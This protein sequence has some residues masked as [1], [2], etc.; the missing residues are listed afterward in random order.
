MASLAGDIQR[1]LDLAADFTPRPSPP[2]RERAS[3]LADLAGGLDRALDGPT[4]QP[5][6]AALGLQV[7]AGGQQ[8]S[9]ALVPWVRIY[10][11]E[12]SPTAQEGIYLTYLFAADGS[13]AY[14]SLMHGSSEFRSGSMR[15]ITDQRVLLARAA[16]ARSALGD[17]AEAGIA[18]GA[19]LSID[20]AWKG[21]RSPDRAKAYESANILART[22]RAG[23][24]PSDAQL[25]ADLSGMLPL[26]ARLYGTEPELLPA[27]GDDDGHPAR[28]A[29]RAQGRE[30][31]PDI[32]RAIE[33]YAENHAAAYF[34]KQKWQVKRVGQYKLGY[35]LACTKPNGATLHVEVKGTRTL[36]EKVT[37]TANEVEHTS[38]AI[39]CGAEHILYVLSQITVTES[40]AITCSGGT[41][42][43]LWPW[44]I[45]ANDLIATEYAYTVPIASDKP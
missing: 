5:W 43:R 18:A 8:G 42:T 3:V 27:D 2:M 17:M 21:F 28:P 39:D 14:L 19:S 40:G 20:L 25:L 13:Q 45:S 10:A 30:H 6:R 44:T 37:L 1:A 34:E 12:Q 11:P 29:V 36:G 33:Q 32:R 26:L 38:H 35:D 22:Y 24:I 41:P 9:V 16:V 7:R 23:Q 4:G 31:D 15:A